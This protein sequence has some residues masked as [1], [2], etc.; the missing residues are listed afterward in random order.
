LNS[1]RLNIFGFPGSPVLRNNLGLL[2]HRLALEWTRDNIAAFGGDPDRITIFGQSAG[3]SAVDYYTYAWVD[4]PIIAGSICQSGAT[5]N[6]A[7]S[8]FFSAAAWYNVTN[9]LG[10][11]NYFSD[12]LSVVSCMRS[13]DWQVIQNAIVKGTGFAGVTGMFGP[14]IDEIVVFSDYP[15]RAITGKIIRKPLMIGNNHNEPGLFKP[16]FALQDV[17]YPDF[18]WNTLSF[19]F[20][21]ESS[22]RALISI[23]NGLPTWRYRWFGDFPN[24]ELTTLPNSGA[25]HGAEIPMIF[26]T[27][28]DVQN[29]VNRTEDEI[30][31]TSYMSGAWAAFARDPVNGL[32]E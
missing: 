29:S 9:T 31:I 21:C 23:V 14:T 27:D 11:G 12:P 32:I 3:A 5:G 24:L 17:S 13:K 2:D 6:Q 28:M 8:P 4:D 15:V 20:T 7:A 18:V 22:A 26:G 10:C 16:L 1:Y 25:W 30:Q 19:M